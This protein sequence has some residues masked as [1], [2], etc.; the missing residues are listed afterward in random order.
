[1][2]EHEH[3]Y[4]AVSCNEI[5]ILLYGIQR[6]LRCRLLEYTV[7]SWCA[8]GCHR[9]EDIPRGE[10]QWSGTMGLPAAAACGRSGRGGRRLNQPLCGLC[11]CPQHSLLRGSKCPGGCGCGIQVHVCAWTA[12]PCSCTLLMGIHAE[13][14]LWPVAQIR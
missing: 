6:Q 14:S 1:M 12:I 11:V 13:G 2:D 8:T 9:F 4:T 5:F 3:H 7:C 10:S